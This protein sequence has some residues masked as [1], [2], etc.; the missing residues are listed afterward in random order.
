VRQIINE[1]VGNYRPELAEEYLSSLDIEEL[2]F[3]WMGPPERHAPHYFRLQGADF[4]FEYD[5]VQNDG[6]HVHSVW[7]SK[8]GDFGPDALGEH[9]R[10]SH[11][12]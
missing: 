7:R 10:T 4:M 11:L 1:V 12:R 5:N 6:N 8:A 9:Y 3:A 2:K